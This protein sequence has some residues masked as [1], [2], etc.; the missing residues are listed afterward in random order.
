MQTRLA[1]FFWFGWNAILRKP[2]KSLTKLKRCGRTRIYQHS[3]FYGISFRS[4]G[5]GY[6]TLPKIPLSEQ[7]GN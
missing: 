2:D 5:C 3:K 7:I 1:Y 6:S 4:T